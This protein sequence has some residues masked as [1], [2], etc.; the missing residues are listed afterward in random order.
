MK[1]IKWVNIFIALRTV[2]GMWKASVNFEVCKFNQSL[3]SLYYASGTMLSMVNTTGERGRGKK[4]MFT[5]G[6]NKSL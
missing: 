3:L 4:L 2:A 6:L 1:N 5:E